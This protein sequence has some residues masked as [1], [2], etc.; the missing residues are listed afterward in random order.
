MPWSGNAVGN[1]TATHE[2]NWRTANLDLVGDIQAPETGHRA[3]GS[4]KGGVLHVH[5][6]II[7]TRP[8]VPNQAFDDKPDIFAG[9]GE[10]DA[11]MVHFPP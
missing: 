2:A 7:R 5:H 1:T 3:F 6:D 8:V 4:A 9:T 10:I 11:L